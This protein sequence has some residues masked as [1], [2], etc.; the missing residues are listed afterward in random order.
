[1]QHLA[2]V[3]T[4]T[5][6]DKLFEES[7]NLAQARNSGNEKVPLGEEGSTGIGNITGYLD[8]SPLPELRWPSAY[9][10]YNRLRRTDP[11]VSV[12]RLMMTLF[13]RSVRL[14][15]RSGASGQNDDEALKYVRTMFN[16]MEGGTNSLI[17]AI[18]SYTP[19]MGFS[20]WEKIYGFRNGKSYNGWV[21]RYTDGLPAIRKLS[22][23]DHSTW[24]KWDFDKDDNL[25]GFQQMVTKGN[26]SGIFRL[27]KSKLLHL[28]FGDSVSPEG[29]TP[30]E[31]I[32]RLER[33]KY[34]F[35]VIFGI[36]A[37]HTAGY[38]SVDAEK[39]LTP[40]DRNFIETTVSNVMKAQ[41]NNY[42]VFPPGF[43][44]GIIDSPFAA[45][46]IILE[47][48]RF[49]GITKLQLFLMHFV[50]IGTT[51]GSG[52]Y[53]SIK[54][55]SDL[56][57]LAFNSMMQ[58]FAASINEQI[59]NPLFRNRFVTNKFGVIEPPVC[60]FTSVE[61]PV[62]LSDLGVFLRHLNNIVE[63]TEEDVQAIR[64]RSAFL[65]ERPNSKTT[66]KSN[67]TI[68]SVTNVEEVESEPIIE[69]EFVNEP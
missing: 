62:N 27:P 40:S 49:Y 42:A 21:S 35:E 15:F 16:E 64:R 37:E 6:E 29:L 28:T 52:S 50:S 34:G 4:E 7:F 2:G 19:F 68:S 54:D 51:S 9:K 65:P 63:F 58:G 1:M 60:Y 13:G 44:G 24:F 41:E 10:V 61:K 5:Y 57:I 43:K 12:A 36:G 47:A 67:D 17:D 14:E 59:I 69:E 39:R 8:F 11:E 32:Y 45:A 20:I 23:R 48:I 30:L 18:V 22:W 38:F 66:G 46:S 31:A 55:A 25:L 56:S 3:K 33:M 53:S 26:K